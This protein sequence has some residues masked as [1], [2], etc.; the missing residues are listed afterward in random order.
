[1]TASRPDTI[2]MFARQYLFKPTLG[3]T[4]VNSLFTSQGGR[5]PAS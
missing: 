3:A 2:S 1:M 5:F 4:T